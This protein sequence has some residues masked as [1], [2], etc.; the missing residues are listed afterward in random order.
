MSDEKTEVEQHKDM[1]RELERQLKLLKHPTSPISENL[2]HW[3]AEGI[4]R[5]LSGN[6]S[7]LDAA[8]GLRR[9]PGRPKETEKQR[10]KARLTEALRDQGKTYREITDIYNLND[11]DAVLDESAVTKAHRKYTNELWAEE[12]INRL[13]AEKEDEIKNSKKDT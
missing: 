12:A 6:E 13:N 3:A 1:L 7:S 4:E 8:L 11:P 2:A 10:Q 5:Y 9:K